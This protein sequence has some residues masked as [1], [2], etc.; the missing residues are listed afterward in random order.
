MAN[1]QNTANSYGLVLLAA[2]ASAR[3]GKPK[4]LLPFKGNTL[5]GHGLRVAIE[6]GVKP[7]VLVLGANA[8]LLAAQ[9]ETAGVE[10]VIN[11][12]WKE[13][14]ASSIRCG[15]RQLLAIA[16][17]TTA[18]IVMVCDQPFI[19]AQLLKDLVVKY[20]QSAKPIIASSYKGIPG[21]P[22]LFDK[23]IFAELMELTGDTGA[24]KI[25]QSDPERVA[26]VEFVLG[27][28]DI[29]TTEDYERLVKGF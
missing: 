4:Q 10:I 19:M 21:T 27:E 20:K 7:I 25:M 15:L 18:I 6:S 16:P 2:G 26:T 13:G 1:N 23:T 28:I 24:K 17:G 22:A 3:L 9:V 29:D 5:L 14:M 12:D 11:A 8:A